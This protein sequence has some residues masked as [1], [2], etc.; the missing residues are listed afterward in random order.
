[1]INMDEQRT[2]WQQINDSILAYFVNFTND[3]GRPI[4]DVIKE[5][6]EK[7]EAGT[8]SPNEVDLVEWFKQ[9]LE[10]RVE[11]DKD[12]AAWLEDVRV[13]QDLR[14]IQEETRG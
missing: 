5:C 2:E 14:K 11:R 1:M 12:R 7:I 10:H 13:F 6:C 9:E 3:G 4:M 8:A